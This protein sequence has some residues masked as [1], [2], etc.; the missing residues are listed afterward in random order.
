M[1]SHTARTRTARLGELARLVAEAFRKHELF[2]Y[3]SAI[4]FRALVSLVPLTL[5]GLAL[6][7]AF[8]LQDVWHDTLS[9]ALQGWVTQPVH[10]GIDF[11]VRK[12]LESGTAGLIA[13]AV[14]LLLYD[15]SWAVA[16][17]MRA[18]NRIHDAEET[19]PWPRRLLTAVAL[20]AAV[21]VCLVASILVVLVAP[22]IEEGPADVV[23]SIARWPLGVVLLGL[24]VGLLVRYAPAERPEAR[25]ASAGS[26]L[27]IGSWLAASLAF[28]WYV[29][30][31]ADFRTAVGSLTVFLVLTAYV[32]TS[33]ALFLVGVQ[34][35]EFLRQDLKKGESIGVVERLRA[36]FG[37]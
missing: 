3:A 27:V 25:W 31:V 2:T 12:I 6:L 35:D 7:G 28:G 13:F 22:R 4:A 18:L 17:V 33:A 37:R 19:R 29:T 1:P 15:L 26:V 34:L 16:A 9:P 21:G 24:A 30:S 23:L 5:L 20:A 10:G 36:A 11:S 14:A 8:G 32:F